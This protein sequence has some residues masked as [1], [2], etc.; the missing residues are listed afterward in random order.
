MYL[1][2]FSEALLL[3]VGEGGSGFYRQVRED[4]CPSRS[5]PPVLTLRSTTAL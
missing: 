1:L 3:M 4:V 5:E 2:L